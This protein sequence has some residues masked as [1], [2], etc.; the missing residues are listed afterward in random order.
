MT[1]KKIFINKNYYL[2]TKGFIHPQ[3]CTQKIYE[4]KP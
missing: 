3:K 2:K 4:I 1:S